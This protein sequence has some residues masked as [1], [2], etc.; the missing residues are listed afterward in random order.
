MLETRG[1][2]WQPILAKGLVRLLFADARWAG[3]EVPALQ[4][5]SVDTMGSGSLFEFP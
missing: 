5:F 4:I 1:F 2:K 3:V